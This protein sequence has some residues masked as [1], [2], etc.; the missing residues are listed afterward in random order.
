MKKPEYYEE[1][2]TSYKYI[3]LIFAVILAYIIV[4]VVGYLNTEKYQRNGKVSPQILTVSKVNEKKQFKILKKYYVNTHKIAKDILSSDA[5]IANQMV[6]EDGRVYT[7][8]D[9]QKKF[10]DRLEQIDEELNYEKGEVIKDAYK[11]IQTDIAN[12]YNLEAGYFQYALQSVNTDDLD[13]YAEKAQS[14]LSDITI[15]DDR[16][17][18]NLGKMADTIGFYD[19][20]V[21]PKDYKE[22][23]EVEKEGE[24]ASPDDC[25]KETVAKNKKIVSPY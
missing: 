15:L 12:L 10:G 21:N 17:K 13:L 5:I 4:V 14:L 16:I 11:E 2:N 9:L 24:Y 1:S 19:D 18:G 8:I 20:D 23:I 22:D 6:G 3:I 7:S 25:S